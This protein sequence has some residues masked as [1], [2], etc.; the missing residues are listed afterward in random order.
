[1][2]KVT[3][4]KAGRPTLKDDSNFSVMAGGMGS[5]VPLSKEKDVKI[6]YTIVNKYGIEEEWECTFT[7][8]KLSAFVGKGR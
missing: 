1:M 7:P 2:T 5:P 8:I 6:R 3:Q 4:K